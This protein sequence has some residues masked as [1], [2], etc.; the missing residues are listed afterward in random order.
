MEALSL[1]RS[2]LAA[3]AGHP[4]TT[5]EYL[6]S[7]SYGRVPESVEQVLL[8]AWSPRMGS[9]FDNLGLPEAY[10]KWKYHKLSHSELPSKLTDGFPHLSDMMHPHT[11][12]READC[13]LSLN[14]YC[15]KVCVPRFVIQKYESGKQRKFPQALYENLAIA[16]GFELANALREHCDA[17]I[18]PYS[19]PVGSLERTGP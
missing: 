3:L 1:N 17:Y 7:G 14:D 19:P 6:E 13:N 9:P 12:W 4:I 2:Q 8:P 16:C 15:G 18:K 5:I 11:E 10:I